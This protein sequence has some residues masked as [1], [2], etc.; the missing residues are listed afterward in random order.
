MLRHCGGPLAS[1]HVAFDDSTN[2]RCFFFHIGRV[3]VKGFED[4]VK[5]ARLSFAKHIE[6][7]DDEVARR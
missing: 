4:A 1:D 2:R 6:E 3:I 7:R 5:T